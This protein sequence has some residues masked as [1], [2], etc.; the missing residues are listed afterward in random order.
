MEAVALAEM[1]MRPAAE[2]L[3]NSKGKGLRL[4]RA[5]AVKKG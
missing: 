1:H 2:P 3:T 4:S 5:T